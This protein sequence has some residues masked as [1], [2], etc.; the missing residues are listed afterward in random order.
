MI[1]YFLTCYFTLLLLVSSTF[2]QQKDSSLY[3]LTFSLPTEAA[4]F[5]IDQLQQIYTISPTNQLKRYASDGTFQFEYNNNTLGNLTRVSVS[6]PFSLLLFYGDFRTL[7]TLDR[8]LTEKNIFDLYQLDVNEIKAVAQ[9]SDNNV[10]LYDDVQFKLKKINRQGR[11]LIESNDL[12]LTLGRALFP[13]YIIEKDNRVYVNDPAVGILVFDILGQYLKTLDVRGLE[14]FQIYNQQLIYA[15][16]GKLHSFHLQSLLATTI[17]LP[18]PL[19][20]EAQLFIQE[21]KLFWLE[22]GELKVYQ[23]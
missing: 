7:I 13:T 10:W 19:S 5:N 22:K 6:N 11:I 17:Q 15:Q 4:Y 3:Q 21:G 12:S 8:N 20:E 14:R 18:R 2:A 1:R 9:S 16:Q 23:Y